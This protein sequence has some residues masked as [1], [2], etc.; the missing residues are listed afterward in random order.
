[1]FSGVALY[2]FGYH[3]KLTSLFVEKIGFEVQTVTLSQAREIAKDQLFRFNTD[4]KISFMIS[5]PDKIIKGIHILRS[6]L[7]SPKPE[8]FFFLT[9]ATT[10]MCDSRCTMCSI[11]QKYR[12][13]PL[14]QNEELDVQEIRNAFRNSKFLKNIKILLIGGGEPF[15]KDDFSEIIILLRELS[16]SAAIIIASSGLDP[17]LIED[18]LNKIKQGIKSQNN[19][20]SFIGVGVS[21]DGTAITHDRMRGRKGSFKRALKTIET[22]GEMEGMHVGIAFTFTPQ[23]Y[24]K[25]YSV[26][27]LANAMKIGLTFQFAQTSGHYYDNTDKNFNWTRE[28]IDEVRGI[29]KETHYFDVI[30]KGFLDYGIGR[31][32]KDRLLDYNRFL[33]E[34]VLDY[35]LHPGRKFN[36]FS[37]THSGFLDPYGNVFPCISLGKSM[38]NIREQRFDTIWTSSIANEV[39]KHISRRQCH[40]CSFCD[41]PLSLPRN[42]SVMTSNLKSIF[43]SK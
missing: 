35:Q 34:Y 5:I 9:F 20:D 43:L 32:F 14:L 22:I 38:G 4:R 23:N 30:R 28:Q 40:C 18:K 7:L 39:R 10:Y 26:R 16:P 33:L 25:F 27:D 6:V 1:V 8:D 11:W 3:S 24:K 2:A 41:I 19:G 15:L 37:G 31:S 13:D 17:T 12:K 21:L 36:C 42:L 29:L